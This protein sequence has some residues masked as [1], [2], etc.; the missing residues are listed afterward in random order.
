MF[1]FTFLIGFVLIGRVYMLLP[2]TYDV[3]FVSFSTTGEGYV[4]VSKVRLTG[5]DHRINGTFEVLRDMGDETF[6]VS[7]ETFNDVE[8]NGEFK[9]LPF[10]MPK[11]PICKMLRTYWS[12][13][14]ASVKYGENTDY[15]VDTLPCPIPKGT[16]YVKDVEINTDGWP[17]VIP[18]GFLK[19]VASLYDNNEMVGTLSALIHVT[20]KHS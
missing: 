8:G 13:A 18:R 9:Q 12:Y 2:K 16:Y 10:Y 7:G 20:D 1:K 14:K 15:P 4:D 19:G 11:Q 5:R 6:S 17:M 3:R